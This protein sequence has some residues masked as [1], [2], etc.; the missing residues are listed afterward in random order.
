MKTWYVM[1]HAKSDWNVPGTDDHERPL[2]HRGKRDAPRMGKAINA[3]GIQLDLVLSS[4]AVRA[5]STAEAFVAAGGF[6]TE[7]ELAPQLYQAGPADYFTV[8]SALERSVG[9]VMTV[10]HNPGCETIIE[11]LTGEATTM[12]T[13][14]VAQLE[15]D[16]DS[17]KQLDRQT[18]ARLK[19][20]WRPKDIDD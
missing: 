6:E 9:S 5:R 7:V 19:K 10:A 11:L 13:G 8:L 12:S 14:A 17:W 16:I 4:S 2:N 18:P 3:A 1:R 20:V 15:L